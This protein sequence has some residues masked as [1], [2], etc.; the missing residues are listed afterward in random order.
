MTCET[1]RSRSSSEDYPRSLL[2]SANPWQPEAT[3][4]VRA[5]PPT[6]LSSTSRNITTA[7]GKDGMAHSVTVRA[8]PL[9]IPR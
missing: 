5:T 8:P 3:Q 1:L 2:T 7:P 9:D 6:R 4:K